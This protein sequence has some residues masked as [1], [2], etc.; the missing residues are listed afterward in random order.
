MGVGRVSRQSLW[1][2][3]TFTEDRKRPQAVSAGKGPE[4]H[5][6]GAEDGRAGP[7]RQRKHPFGEYPTCRQA[8]LG[9]HPTSPAF[10][11]CHSR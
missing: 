6:D 8:P 5:L 1:D 7:V 9:L 4:E 11:L 10:K 2:W 3:V